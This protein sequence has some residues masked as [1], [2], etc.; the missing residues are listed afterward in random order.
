MAILEGGAPLPVTT[1]GTGQTEARAAVPVYVV[2][3]GQA[4]IGQR[5]RRVV[6]MTSGPIEGGAAHPVYDAGVGAIPSGEAALP[7]YV[8][9]GSLGGFAASDGAFTRPSSLFA[10]WR[11]GESVGATQISDV[12]HGY[13]ATPAGDMVLGAASLA[14]D[15]SNTAAAFGGVSGAAN[16]AAALE[17]T[18]DWERTQAWTLEFLIKPNVLRSG[19][20]KDYPIFSKILSTGT[21]AGIEVALQWSGT[22]TR[23]HTWLINNFGGANRTEGYVSVDLANATTYHIVVAYDG[24][25]V[26]T[27]IKYYINGVLQSTSGGN[28]LSASILN[29]IVPSIGG[30]GTVFLKANL[31]ELA[32]YT[33]QLTQS[34]VS[35][36]YGMSTY[37]P[38]ASPG[39]AP[40]PILVSSDNASD[41]GDTTAL[42]L[43]AQLA[44]NGECSIVA[45]MTDSANVYS[46]PAMKAV[47]DHYG[48]STTVGAWQ[49]ATPAGAPSASV[50]TQQVRDRFK[51]GQTRADYGTPTTVGRTALAA[52]S[53]GTVTVLMLGFATALREVLDSAADG[54]S[55]LTGSALISAKVKRLVVMGGKYPSDAGSPEFNFASDP[56]NWAYIEA[57]WPTEIVFVGYEVGLPITLA[58]PSG[59]DPLTNPVAYAWNLN[60][61]AGVTRP[62]WDEMTILMAVRGISMGAR[63]TGQHGTNTINSSTGANT[64]AQTP[65]AGDA[66]I[67]KTASDASFITTITALLAATA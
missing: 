23:I 20:A 55:G 35:Y 41:A 6:V 7:V 24:G 18:F 4:P 26:G 13:T 62:A 11:L 31:D 32:M 46:A 1:G 30:R 8:V 51:A 16:F 44:V 37:G 43:L 66:W 59:N 21:S 25:S 3:G 19:G 22:I 52:A 15:T 28:T 34:D 50:Y 45:A 49:G 39:T 42:A 10:M 12:K 53:N 64:W 14:F 38:I 27:N 54:I 57:N 60:W 61:G 36:L 56:A 48:L 65:D 58:P 2:S 40:V 67:E 17:P 9:Q 29:D 47:F 63:V 33:A 5:P